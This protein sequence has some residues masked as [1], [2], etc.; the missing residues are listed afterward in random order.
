MSMSLTDELRDHVMPISTAVV[1]VSTIFL[2]LSLIWVMNVEEAQ[3]SVIEDY[4]EAVGAWNWW[5]LVIALVGVFVGG[6]YLYSY[7]KDSRKFEK[8]IDT[9][10]KAT[11]LR[12]MEELDEL[13]W[14][15]PGS[16]RERFYEKRAQ[17]KIK[18]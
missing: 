12:N 3:V 15:L 16:Y 10:S 2:V 11:F 1:A 8:L 9:N 17:F 5:I 14:E 6:Y 4:S 18:K 13:S 7:I